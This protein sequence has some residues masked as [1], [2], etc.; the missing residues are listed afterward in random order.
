MSNPR[1]RICG[2]G[3]GQEENVKKRQRSVFCSL[4]CAQEGHKKQINNHWTRKIRTENSIKSKGKN[5]WNT[6]QI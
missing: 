2:K 4:K 1:C 6:N 3:F 5:K